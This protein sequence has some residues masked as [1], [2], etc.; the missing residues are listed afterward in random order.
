MIHRTHREVRKSYQCFWTWDIIILAYSWF[1]NI[2]VVFFFHKTFYLI[3]REFPHRTVYVKSL[4]LRW[5][6]WRKINRRLRIAI[7]LFFTRKHLRLWVQPTHKN[8]TKI[9]RIRFAGI[10]TKIFISWESA[11][12]TELVSPIRKP[13]F[14]K[15]PQQAVTSTGNNSTDEKPQQEKTRNSA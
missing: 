6:N 11:S 3:H 4:V 10:P 7:K 9:S 15:K 13:Y 2:F 1:S 12:I 14:T 5:L 8:F